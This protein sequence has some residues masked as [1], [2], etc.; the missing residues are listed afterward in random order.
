[1]KLPIPEVGDPVATPTPP[2]FLGWRARGFQRPD[3]TS[4]D[5]IGRVA[6][7]SCDRIFQGATTHIYTH[8][9]AS[10]D[11]GSVYID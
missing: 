9:V 2:E 7:G 5:R 1:M 8:L 6:M 10:R 4:R 11:I 3:V